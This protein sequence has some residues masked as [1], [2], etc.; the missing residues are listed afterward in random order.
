M[1]DKK[2]CPSSYNTTRNKLKPITTAV[3]ISKSVKITIESPK[4]ASSEERK[5]DPTF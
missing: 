1:K 3:S 5:N 4:P 2:K